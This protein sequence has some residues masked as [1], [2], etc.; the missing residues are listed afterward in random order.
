MGGVGE[1][2]IK[3]CT[4]LNTPVSIGGPVAFLS[5]SHGD[6]PHCIYRGFCIQ[7]CKVGAKASTPVTHVPD[8]VV[9]GAAIRSFSMVSRVE[10]GRNNRVTGV[11]YFDKDGDELERRAWQIPDGTGRQRGDGPVR[12]AGAHV[13]GAARACADREV[14]RDQPEERLC[15]RLRDPD[16]G[17]GAAA[18]G[19][20]MLAAKKAWGWGLRRE[21]MGLQPLVRVRSARRDTPWNDFTSD[22]RDMTS[23]PVRPEL[24]PPGTR[25]KGVP[26]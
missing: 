26:R 5:G 17:S 13:Q 22:K 15:A 14:L 21:M 8:A 24:A 16:R 10:L 4:A 1:T 7:G 3:S 6:R 9:K 25:G 12:R 2:L 19:K 18:F 11:H 20:Q 23:P